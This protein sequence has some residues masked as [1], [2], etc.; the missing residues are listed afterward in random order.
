MSPVELA[1]LGLVAFLT[2]FSK[3]ALG[4]MLTPLISLGLVNIFPVEF[5]IGIQLPMLM[6]ADHSALAVHWKNWDLKLT[7]RLIL[8]GL[9]GIYI[10]SQL[11]GVINEAQLKQ[12]IALIVMALAVYQISIRL[13]RTRLQSRTRHIPDWIALPTGLVAGVTTTL[14]H[15][16]GPPVA[17]LLLLRNTPAKVYVATMVLTFTVLN[18]V[19][20]PV[21]IQRGLLGRDLLLLTIGLT[22]LV[23]IGAFIGRRIIDQIPQK[24]FELVILALMVLASL[25]ILI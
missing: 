9:G 3:S 19:K 21:Y 2:G 1:L 6:V 25:L 18:W 13:F 12:T 10:G 11:L 16:G 14:A 17:F 4:G 8:G 15:I 22:P 7:L 24:A 20:L 5:A 23:L